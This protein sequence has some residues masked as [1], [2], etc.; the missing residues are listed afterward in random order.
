MT[1]KTY[2]TPYI[3]AYLNKHYL[4]KFYQYFYLF[5]Y[6]KLKVYLNH[7]LTSKSSILEQGK[8]ANYVQ[9]IFFK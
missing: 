9:L 6:L 7:L 1:P 2:P 3:L 5:F 8:V 4:L